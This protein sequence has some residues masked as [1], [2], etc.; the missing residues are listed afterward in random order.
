MSGSKQFV[1]PTDKKAWVQHKDAAEQH[2]ER[3]G[4][5]CNWCQ[6]LGIEVPEGCES[7]EGES[8]CK[9]MAQ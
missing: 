3:C 7:K 5:W 6:H 1:Y 2:G 9:G 4:P 8:I